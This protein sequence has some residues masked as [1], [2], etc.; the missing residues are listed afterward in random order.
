MRIIYYA[1]RSI[2][3]MELLILNFYFIFFAIGLVAISV[4]TMKKLCLRLSIWFWWRRVIVRVL[5]I[6]K[7]T[8]KTVLSEGQSCILHKGE[9]VPTLTRIAPASDAFSKC[10]ALER[11]V[12]FYCFLPLHAVIAA[13][14]DNTIYSNK[15]THGKGKCDNPGSNYGTHIQCSYDKNQKNQV[16][17]ILLQ[18]T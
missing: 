6:T 5:K 11:C 13:A 1:W 15:H 8:L 17:C 7:M 14:I 3:C 10:S 18:L 4:C 16:L 12:A 9:K 2:R